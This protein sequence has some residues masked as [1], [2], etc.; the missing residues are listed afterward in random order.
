MGYFTQKPAHIRF[1]RLGL[2]LILTV[3]SILI[4]VFLSMVAWYWWQI[5]QGKSFELL[6]TGQFTSSGKS[7]TAPAIEDRKKLESGFHPSLGN[8]AAPI[9]IVEFADFKCP[10]C[11]VAAPILKQV[12]SRYGSKV[13]LIVRDFPFR[14]GSTYL[15]EVGQCALLQNRFWPTHD[16]LYSNQE[17]SSEVF[18]DEQLSAMADVVDLDLP[19]L[20]SCLLDP[21]TE[22]SVMDDYFVGVGAGVRG[23]PTFFVNGQKIEGTIPFESWSK[24]IEGF[25]P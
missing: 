2:I 23:T 11:Q 10:N 7:V 16:Y 17:E 15:A 4:L 24:Y 3:V 21:T 9:T 14:P 20:K 12:L 13:R 5:R 25:H 1:S 18:S 6:S 19:R 22:K 8:A